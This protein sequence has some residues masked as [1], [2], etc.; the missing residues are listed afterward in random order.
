MFTLSPIPASKPIP[1]MPTSMM[2]F[3]P[4][5]DE[6]A[7]DDD[8]SR[9]GPPIS[10]A[11]RSIPIKSKSDSHRARSGSSLL[12]RPDLDVTSSSVPR[13]SLDVHMGSVSASPST[14]SMNYGSRPA[15]DH[16]PGSYRSA[17]GENMLGLR[18]DPSHVSPSSIDSD[19][20]EN[21][22]R[23][24]RL[25]VLDKI[26]DRGAGQP[27]YS[28]KSPHKDSLS[29][30]SERPLPANPSTVS[31]TRTPSPISSTPHSYSSST[32]EKELGGAPPFRPLLGPVSSASSAAA[33]RERARA[34]S[35][36]SQNAPPVIPPPPS[37]MS[38][39]PAP[40]PNTSIHLSHVTAT[41]DGAT[42]V[43]PVY[44]PHPQPTPVPQQS[45][46]SQSRR[47]STDVYPPMSANTGSL[48][49]GRS[50]NLGI[51]PPSG[52]TSGLTRSIR[53]M[54]EAPRVS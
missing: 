7:S 24:Q 49:R 22:E 20:K 42:P 5:S 46:P 54:Q 1:E 30:G 37:S 33:E 35:V 9:P 3:M 39:H 12:S 45:R 11:S 41:R 43:H 10:S 25:A 15:L 32:M 31:S 51:V 52:Y 48:S 4:L 23:K 38:V 21:Q 8:R 36:N 53:A 40:S 17:V 28:V 34:S 2:A 18:A 27:A 19:L 26:L 14:S 6:D 47:Q 44:G 29:D 13:S 50:T 16:A